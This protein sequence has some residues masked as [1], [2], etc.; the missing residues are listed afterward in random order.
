M[1][2][3]TAIVS[4]NSA[5]ELP[6]LTTPDKVYSR[7]PAVWLPSVSTLVG[8][9]CTPTTRDFR[10]RKSTRLNSSHRCI[11]YAVFCLKKKKQTPRKHDYITDLKQKRIANR[12]THDPQ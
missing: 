11:S 4:N 12:D 7:A 10:D 3:K 9:S 8:R 2:R 1:P 5:L 6:T